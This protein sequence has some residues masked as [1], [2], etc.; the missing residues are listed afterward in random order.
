ML[1]I[2]KKHGVF[3]TAAILC[4]MSCF[5][6]RLSLFAMDAASS[7]S[8]LTSLLAER[9]ET[10]KTRVEMIEKLVGI[11]RSTPEALLTARDDL[12]NA[13]LEMATNHNERIGVLQE[14]LGNAK[15]LEL[16]MQQR[17]R[18][19]DGTEAE[20]LMAKADRLRIEIE[21]LRETEQRGK[22]Q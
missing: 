22:S 17:K 3:F 15:Q 2:E 6:V 9:R 5:A 8:K 13:E 19:A 7:K 16:I 11:A 14:K 10:L 21:L 20:V 18:D 4:V 12:F 1:L